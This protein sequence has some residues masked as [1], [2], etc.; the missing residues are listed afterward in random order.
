[1]VMNINCN[2]IKRKDW[3]GWGTKDDEENFNK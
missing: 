3:R 2:Y 1:M